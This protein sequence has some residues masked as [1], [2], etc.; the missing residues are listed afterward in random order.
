MVERKSLPELVSSIVEVRPGPRRL[1]GISD[2]DDYHPRCGRHGETPTRSDQAS[3][4]ALYADAGAT[5]RS[6]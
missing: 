5:R 3:G 2:P 4:P 6:T 1:A